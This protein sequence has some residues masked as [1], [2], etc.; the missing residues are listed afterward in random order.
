MPKT[1]CLEC[2]HDF[3]RASDVIAKNKPTPGDVSL[4]I[5]CA[6]IAMFD[7]DLTLRSITEREIARLPLL[8]LSQMQAAR[9]AV[10]LNKGGGT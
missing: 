10:L 9:A 4:C 1:R 8:I 3:D 2:G 5:E 6:N 7:D